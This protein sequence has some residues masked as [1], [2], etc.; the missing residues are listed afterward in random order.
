MLSNAYFLAKVRF[1]TAEN[2]PAKNL[3]N[4]LLE[5]VM[6]LILP[7]VRDALRG[8]PRRRRGR[9][10]ARGR[11]P[12]PQDVP[13]RR[14]GPRLIVAKFWRMLLQLWRMLAKICL[15]TA[16]NEPSEVSEKLKNLG[17]PIK[18]SVGGNVRSA[19]GRSS[20]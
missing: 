5:S 7:Q 9:G 10:R 4:L 8:A 17:E 1:D 2:E 18:S 11:R 14:Q 12:L 16:K 3:Q 15:D 13:R 6:L 19:R 20:G